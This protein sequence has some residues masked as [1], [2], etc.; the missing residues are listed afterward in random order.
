MHVFEGLHLTNKNIAVTLIN[1][2]EALKKSTM[3]PV[4]LVPSQ[5]SKL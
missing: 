5:W 2:I 3:D 4:L 1:R